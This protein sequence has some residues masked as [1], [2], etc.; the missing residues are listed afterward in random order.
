MSQHAS[1]FST[2]ETR[3]SNLA[4]LGLLVAV[5]A[6]A[7]ALTACATEGASSDRSDRPSK[8][9]A[10]ANGAALY[11]QK[12]GSCHGADLKGTDRGPS[13]LSV[14]YAPDHHPDEAYRSA[15]ANGARAH[16][17]SFGD[18]APVKGLTADQVDAIIDYVRAQQ[19]EHGL[20]AYPPK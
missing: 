7:M 16:H 18:M 20:E 1:T 2:S 15:I 12:C 13:Q 10:G 9:G 17:W 8:T 5:V 11:K 19:R 4:G 3:R 6:L 14:V